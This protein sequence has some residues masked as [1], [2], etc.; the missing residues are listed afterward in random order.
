MSKF[1]IGDRVRYSHDRG[2]GHTGDTGTV[3][4]YTSDG[5]GVKWDVYEGRSAWDVGSGTNWAYES[6]LVLATPTF[7]KGDRVR[8]IKDGG[9]RTVT[10]RS[11]HSEGGNVPLTW[12][13]VGAGGALAENLEL[14]PPVVKNPQEAGYNYGKPYATVHSLLF[15]QLQATSYRLNDEARE[16]GAKAW[17][18]E[19]LLRDVR[20][21]TTQVQYNLAS[22]KLRDYARENDLSFGGTSAG[23]FAKLAEIPT[24]VLCAWDYNGKPVCVGDAVR[25]EWRAEPEWDRDAKVIGVADGNVIRVQWHDGSRGDWPAGKFVR[26]Q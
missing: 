12:D 1:K 24:A 25:P 16:A 11:N 3:T 6:N 17:K 8:Y 9:K 15:D 19:Q 22:A 23:D 7:K 26:V 18:L 10:V 5:V 20:I 21:A 2:H 4:G 13:D 14:L